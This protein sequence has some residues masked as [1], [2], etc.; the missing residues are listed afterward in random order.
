MSHRS[1]FIM[2]G[3]G[4]MMGFILNIAIADTSNKSESDMKMAAVTGLIA[5][6]LGAITGFFWPVTLTRGIISGSTYLILKAMK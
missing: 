6:P 2:M 5:V 1:D 3:V 4:G